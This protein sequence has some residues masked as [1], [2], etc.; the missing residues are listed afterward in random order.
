MK[1]VLVTQSAP[2][3][4]ASF[5]DEL[6]IRLVAAGHRVEGV[7]ALAPTFKNSF[8]EE[9]RSRWAFYG[10]VDFIRMT[11]RIA[12]NLFLARF[13]TAACHSVGNVVEK[14]GLEPLNFSSVNNA[15]LRTFI[16]RRGID[17]VLSIASPQIFRRRLLAAPRHGCLNYHMGLLPRFRGRQ[18]LFWAMLHDEPEV[19]LTVHEMDTEL[20]N[21]PIIAQKRFPVTPGDSLH[22]LYL[23]CVAQGPALVAGAIDLIAEGDGTRLPNDAEQATCFGFPSTEDVAGFRAQGKKF[24]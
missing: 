23:K 1:L 14:H 21:G 8:L 2:M 11:G 17:V 24:F 13:S 20:D 12:M 9:V 16:E 19:G 5:L 10:P 4:L 7:V 3:Y 22:Q 6:V 18:P 15:A